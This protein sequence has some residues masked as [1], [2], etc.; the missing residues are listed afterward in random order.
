MEAIKGP[1]SLE[2]PTDIQNQIIDL[3]LC[4]RYIPEINSDI[5]IVNNIELFKTKLEASQKP[6]IL[7][8]YGIHLSNS[9]NKFRSYIDKHSIPFVSTF[10]AKDII[11]YNHPLNIGIIGIKGSR[12][13]NYAIQKCDLLLI[14]GSSL[15]VSHIGYD[16]NLFSP[17]SEKILV[18]IDESDYLKNNVKIDLFFKNDIGDFLD[19]VI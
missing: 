2:V 5:Q 13:G 16:E 17:N 19:N 1:C 10:L 4:A 11:E 3:D 12:A 9:Q 18:N 6:L 14:L 15:G 8:G 7:A